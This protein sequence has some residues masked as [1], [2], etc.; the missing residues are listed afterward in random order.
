[1]KKSLTAERRNKIAKIL[2]KEGSI[3]V[4]DLS[5]R[6]NVSTETI[7]K[8]IIYLDEEGLAHKSFGGAVAPKSLVEKSID[9]K[10]LS[11]SEE[12][13]EI[14]FK[15]ASLIAPNSSVLLDAGSTTKALARQ[16]AL[17]SGLKI[18]TNSVTIAALLAVSENDLFITGGRVRKSSK[19]A[20]G[21]WGELALERI[22]VDYAFLGSDGFQG[23]PGPS[24]V[25][26]T[27]TQFKS[28]AVQAADRVYTV[29]DSSKFE[30]NGLFSYAPWKD[31]TAL[32]TNHGAPEAA[33]K[34]IKNY[35]DVILA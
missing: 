22:H 15:A 10:E 31:I 25:S 14:A 32:I 17:Q 19:A 11:G 18:F 35:T 4:G 7:R 12:K 26:Y 5:K 33:I 2:M 21:A 30:T 16:L 1:M 23:L 9:E 34:E 27:E 20:V 28:W 3:K 29:A 6:F 8:D 24:A 13:A